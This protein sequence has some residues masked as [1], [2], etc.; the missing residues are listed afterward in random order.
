VITE[1]FRFEGFDATAFKR[2]VQLFGGSTAPPERAPGLLVIKLDAAGKPCAAM[3]TGRGPVDVSGFEGR[4][5]QLHELCGRLNVLGAV[6]IED[7]ALTDLVENAAE[8]MRF[9]DDYVQHWLSMVR[10]TRALED[11]GRI[12]WWPRR[13]HLPIPTPAM[14]TRALDLMLPPRRSL[15]IALWEGESLWAGCAI[16]R[17]DKDLT[18]IVGPDF[19]LEWAGPL[20]GDF[21]R[22]HRTLTGAVSSAMAPVHLGLFAQREAFQALLR[23]A[24]PGAWAQAVAMREIIISPAAPYVHVA[25]GADALRAAGKRTAAA[26]GGVDL[27]SYIG[28]F[29]ALARQRV[30]RVSS[31]TN[32]LGFN[33]LSA[34]ASRLRR[35]SQASPDDDSQ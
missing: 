28:P 12:L 22:D 21:R 7:G 29:A 24:E 16:E 2:L 32:I 31:L 8:A 15:V 11:D 20:A 5:E 19:L 30:A 34:L 9:D 25:L 35:S 17:G 10:A 18:R 27:A 26:F 4:P 1:D 6:V 14:L 3:V 23:S 33:P 13:S